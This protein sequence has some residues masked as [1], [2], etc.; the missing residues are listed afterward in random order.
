MHRLTL[1]HDLLSRCDMTAT[2]K[3]CLLR[4]SSASEAVVFAGRVRL[5]TGCARLRARAKVVVVDVVAQVLVDASIAT[6]SQVRITL[7][8]GLRNFTQLQAWRH[9]H[10][11]LLQGKSMLEAVVIAMARGHGSSS[12]AC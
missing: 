9:K 3:G 4:C 7:V 5:Y 6:C 8:N 2:A 12:C 11:D 10:V 1:K